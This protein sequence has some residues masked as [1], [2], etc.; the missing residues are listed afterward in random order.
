[1]TKPIF[2]AREWGRLLCQAEAAPESA[3]QATVAPIKASRRRRCDEM[4]VC[5]GNGCAACP[6]LDHQVSAMLTAQDA[7]GQRGSVW[8]A[9]PEPTT[10]QPVNGDD[11]EP[12]KREPITRIELVALVT[13]IVLS[14][15]SSLAVFSGIWWLAS[16]AQVAA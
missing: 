10:A 13:L 9:E 6:D 2:Q 7:P 14:G 15:A 11:D 16:L 12:L 5:Q 1:M 8:F 3:P 4:G